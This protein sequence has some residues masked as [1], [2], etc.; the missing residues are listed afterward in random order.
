MLTPPLQQRNSPII[1][2]I[3]TE[4]IASLQRAESRLKS[5]KPPT[6]TDPDLFMIKNLLIL[7]NEL[8]T[9][10]I[11]DIRGAGPQSFFAAGSTLAGNLWDSSA[12]AQNLLGGL[13]SGLGGLST[14]IP[15]SSLWGGA[16]RSGVNT[17]VP[18]GTPA[19][20]GGGGGG[21]PRLG[22]GGAGQA[23]DDASEQLD[24]LLRQGIVAFTKRW[25]G[26]LNEARGVGGGKQQL[27]GKN[28][29]K[30]ERELEEMLERAF[31]GQPEVVGKL[32]EAIQIE[33][34]AQVLAA[35]EKKSYV[36]R[37]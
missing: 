29:G 10:E 16:G 21:T 3:L 13:L 18:G 35:G 28:V 12:R 4:S 2:K 1:F 11:G 19:L 8:M 25:A 22:G 7:K 27:G 26:V 23:V 30:V 5:T 37:V 32:K 24:G 9:L 34:Q 6:G 33:A 17:P 15:G 31:S 36:T 14:Y 20:G